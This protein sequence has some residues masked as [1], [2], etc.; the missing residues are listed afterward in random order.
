MVLKVSGLVYSSS[1]SDAASKRC[2]LLLI[3]SR[4]L[5]LLTRCH[6]N[7]NDFLRMAVTDVPKY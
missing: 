2:C 3:S 5:H 7:A 6:H 1:D 4:I